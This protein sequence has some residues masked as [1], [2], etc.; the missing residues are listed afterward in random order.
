MAVREHL[1]AAF[2]LFHLTVV[3]IAGIGRIEVEEGAWNEP[4]VEAWND[5][6]TAVWRH[7]TRRYGDTFGPRMDGWKM[8]SSVSKSNESTHLEVRVG[9]EWQVAYAVERPTGGS[10]FTYYRWR[11][12]LGEVGETKQNGRMLANFTHWFAEEIGRER[13]DVCAVRVR[14]RTATTPDP[15]AL[16]R[17]AKPEYNKVL[18]DRRPVSIRD[19]T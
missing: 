5:V 8:F 12:L 3:S 9:H 15:D 17:G 6:R 18:R 19:C 1:V 13:P 2:T 14:I 4:A 16:A 7:A 10:H 11:E